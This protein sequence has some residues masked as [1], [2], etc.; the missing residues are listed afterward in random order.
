MKKNPFS[1]FD[2]LGYVFPGLITLYLV[3]YFSKSPDIYGISSL[4]KSSISVLSNSFRGATMSSA[5]EETV[6]I[7]IVAYVIGHFV[8][9]ISSVT[10]EQFSVW[11]YD[12]P[13]KFLLKDIPANNFWNSNG[14]I[15]LPLRAKRIWR[16]IISVFLLPI[17]IG[18]I[19]FGKW[20]GVKAFFIKKLD[21]SLITMIYAS[22]KRLGKYLGIQ[23]SKSMDF[24][25][26]VYHYEYENQEKHSFKMDNYVALY[27]FL[28]SM[29]LICNCTFLWIF[30]NYGIC[31]IDLSSK[32]NFKLILL[33][34][35]LLVITYIFFMS[36][37]KFY[38]RFTLESFMCLVIDTTY[39]SNSNGR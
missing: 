17:S 35:S 30:C 16:I 7:T 37:M 31:S 3:W 26:V 1:L 6:L 32:I 2:F 19:V 28:R 27:G 20:F 9:Y 10:V 24:H 34:V 22:K 23:F 12:Y 18:T 33:L 14:E 8:A 36:F 15:N 4:F 11:V 38:R 21:P 13:S 39:K 25:R 29:T 5:I